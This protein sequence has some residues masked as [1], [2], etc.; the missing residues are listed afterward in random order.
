MFN[1]TVF[2]RY[3]AFFDRI[4]VYFKKGEMIMIKIVV[5]SSCDTKKLNNTE[6]IL[7][8]RVPLTIR[9]GETEYVDDDSIDVPAMLDD[10][11]TKTKRSSTACPSPDAWLKSYQGADELYVFTITKNLS[12]S[13]SSAML[14][15]DMLLE[16]NPNVKIHVFD[17]L[18]AG[19]EIRLLVENTVE[20]ISANNSFEEIVSAINRYNSN[21]KL[22]F[23]LYNL[24]ALISNGRLP[25]IA[26]FAT[27]I[28][29][30][31]MLGCASEEGTLKPLH[32]VRGTAKGLRLILSEMI[33]DHF[34]GGK[35]IIS[36]VY[37]ESIAL[38]V[39][40][41]ILKQFPGC[42]IQIMET[43]GLCGYYASKDG[44]LIGYET[45]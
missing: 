37:N 11:A 10:I 23:M 13:Y 26:G 9:V 22:L 36:H 42:P 34:E 27:S 8:E 25:K 15:K 33:S 6:S 12:G 35:V 24:D 43:G 39:K 40:E 3:T 30:I 17:T 18:S 14:A 2:Y 38:A 5:D 45:N 19:P 32:K 4:F 28:L 1:Q 7:Y 31:S 29:G 41:T 44:F 16:Q 20:L 21:T